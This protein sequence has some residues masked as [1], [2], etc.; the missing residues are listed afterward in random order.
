MFQDGGLQLQIVAPRTA[1]RER[2]YIY[3]VI[4]LDFLGVKC[5]TIFA[6]VKDVQITLSG[7]VSGKKLLINDV[8]FQHYDQL[9]FQAASLPSFPLST[10]QLSNELSALCGESTLPVLYGKPVHDCQHLQGVSV[11]RGD[12]LLCDRQSAVLG[13]DIF[14]SAF[15]M[16][17]CYEEIVIKKRDQ[18][19]RFP[20]VAS[21]AYRAGFLHRPLVN[22]YVEI[23]WWTLQ[24]LWPQLQRKKGWFQ[25]L[26]SHDVDVPFANCFSGFA[27]LLRTMAGDIAYRK[28]FGAA[29]QRLCSYP[30]VK[31]GNYKRDMNY[32]FDRI[33][34]IS[35]KYGLQ[36]TFFI[37]T[38][39]THK[40]YD[41][42]YSLG[43]PYVQGLLKS[44]HQRGHHLGLHPSYLSYVDESV[45]QIEYQRLLDCFQTLGIQQVECGGRQHYLRWKSSDTLRYYNNVGL[46]YDTSI[47]YADYVGFKVGTCHEYHA[48]DLQERSILRL[49]ERPLVVMECSV[50]K[51][52]TDKKYLAHTM[53]R[54]LVLK[55][56]CRQF[57]GNFTLLWHNSYFYHKE[58]WNFYDEL[59]RP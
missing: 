1:Q 31:R 58:Y 33:M 13:L 40:S 57:K 35:E 6:D 28:S 59:L 17:T 48:Y 44:V 42:P 24:Q 47:G 20:G 8:F 11:F 26:P 27:K 32:T 39:C 25:I 30:Q 38:G 22:E 55:S 34:D 50:M 37:K 29:L 54:L 2:S 12:Y 18:H 56:K 41:Q 19:D 52:Q 4:F 5:E 23:L 46:S 45:V 10:W 49:R 53:E 21:L 15:F 3:Q 43:H 16:L 7:D 14:G 36:S 9:R 51:N